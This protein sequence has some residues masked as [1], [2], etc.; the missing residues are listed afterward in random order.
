MPF[1]SVD[2]GAVTLYYEDS[3]IPSGDTATGVPYA[4]LVL[5]HGTMFHGATFRPLLPYAAQNNLRVITLNQRDFP[6]STPIRRDEIEALESSDPHSQS[7]VLQS[8]AHQIAQFLVHLVDQYGIPPIQRSRDGKTQGGISLIAWSQGTNML[9]SFLAHLKSLPESAKKVVS[10]HLRSAGFYDPSLYAL[11]ENPQY[12]VEGGKDTSN[13]FYSP[14]RDPTLSMEQT[15]SIF[16]TF[17]SAFYSSLP[18][19]PLY[20]RELTDDLLR[21]IHFRPVI[22]SPER[23]PSVEQMTQEEYQSMVKSDYWTAG[24]GRIAIRQVQPEV[25][26]ANVRAALIK[27]SVA[28]TSDSPESVVDFHP[29]FRILVFWC[30]MTVTEAILGS[31]AIAYHHDRLIKEGLCVHPLYSERIPGANHFAHWHDP[32]RF[33][34]G[35][36]EA[37]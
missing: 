29:A 12:V 4:T 17:V 3:G 13:G 20:S 28:T 37:V 11:G 34:R 16:P 26:Q 1:A 35:V 24:T 18:E 10:T 6:G 9:F 33:L 7:R 23:R 27:K 19:L 15:S 31:S 5:I 32:E 22:Q 36:S 21:S 2:N 25:F 14:L 30:D 8:L